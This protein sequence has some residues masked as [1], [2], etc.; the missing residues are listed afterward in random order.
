MRNV[1]AV[2][3][4][5]SAGAEANA[6]REMEAAGGMPRRGAR[7]KDWMVLAAHNRT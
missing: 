3:F 4:L 2:L 6:R 1:E 7:G 5:V